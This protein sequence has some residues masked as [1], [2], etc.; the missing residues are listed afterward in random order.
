[1][2]Y[3]NDLQVL[4]YP[5]PVL[6]R[7]AAPVTVFD[8]E[9]TDFVERLFA[10][11]DEANGVGL[12]APQVGVSERIFVT[13]HGKREEDAPTNRIVF[14]NPRMENPEGE[15]TYEEGCLSFPGMY[16]RVT[17]PNRFDFV[18]QDVAGAEHRQHFDIEAGDFLGVVVQHEVDHLEGKV[19]LD[20]LSPVQLSGLRRKLRELE[21]EYKADHGTA[22]SVLRR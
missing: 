3:P 22:G 7:K 15:E 4:S 8:A 16:A 20:Y 6:R 18:W 17:R 2:R 10:C 14:I 21:K 1:M 5:A 13:D 11:M 9:L 12:A 19:F